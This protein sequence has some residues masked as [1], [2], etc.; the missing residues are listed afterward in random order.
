MADGAPGIAGFLTTIS[1][2]NWPSSSW[3]CTKIREERRNEKMYSWKTEK[4][5]ITLWLYSGGYAATD[6][7]LSP[8]V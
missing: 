3:G 8:R 5:S 2:I 4:F 6:L 1:T 7:L